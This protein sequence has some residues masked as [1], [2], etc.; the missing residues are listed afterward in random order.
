[1]KKFNKIF[2]WKLR[3]KN[4]Y[5]FKFNNFKLMKMIYK[6]KIHKFNNN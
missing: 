6:K 2:L 1:M 3:K 4:N 5:R